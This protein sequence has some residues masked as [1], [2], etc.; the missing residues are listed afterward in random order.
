LHGNY[1]T[2][3]ERQLFG[4]DV[5]EAVWFSKPSIDVTFESAAEALKT[6]VRYIASGAIRTEQPDALN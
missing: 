4:L 6:S 2:L 3:V 5:S 1:H